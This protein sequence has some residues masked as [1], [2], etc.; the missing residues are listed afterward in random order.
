L[1]GIVSKLSFVGL[2]AAAA[3][4]VYS[5]YLWQQ[6]RLCVRLTAWLVVIT[7]LFPGTWLGRGILLSGYPVYPLTVGAVGAEWQVYCP[8]VREEAFGVY[9][10]SHYA[11]DGDGNVITSGWG[12]LPRWSLWVLQH[13]FEVV[14]PLGVFLAFAVAW[15]ALSRKFEPAMIAIG[16]PICSVVFWFLTAPDPRFVVSSF[17][18]LAIYVMVFSLN[19][20]EK[21]RSVAILFMV[22]LLAATQL[23]HYRWISPDPDTGFY[24]AQVI[25]VTQVE[26]DTG[27]VINVPQTRI[28]SQNP[29]A[30]DRCFASPI[31]CTPYPDP[32]LRLRGENDMR[33]GF[34][35]DDAITCN[36]MTLVAERQ[37]AG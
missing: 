2:G 4:L 32:A 16:I 35:K 24:P 21:H 31:P 14:I 34:V 10:F 7:V 36:E 1:A 12:W 25:E 13:Q 5:A 26:T 28:N 3:V 18:L 9:L 22:I 23:R 30:D 6:R 20:L 17:W 8:D 27:L 15:L 29:M 19:S 33:H 11:L 37:S